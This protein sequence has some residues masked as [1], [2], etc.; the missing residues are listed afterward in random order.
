[1]RGRRRT[2][3]EITAKL[4][5]VAVLVVQGQAIAAAARSIGV[6]QPGSY[7]RSTAQ[8]HST[9]GASKLGNS[10]RHRTG[11]RSLAGLVLSLASGSMAHAQS[12]CGGTRFNV[13]TAAAE[14]R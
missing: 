5:N 6:T 4:R 9:P 2:P 11:L 8:G 10:S 7:I 1:M 13:Q 12:P 14:S 3:K